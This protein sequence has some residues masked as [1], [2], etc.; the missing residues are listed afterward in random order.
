MKKWLSIRS[1]FSYGIVL[2]VIVLVIEG[3]MQQKLGI[4]PCSLCIF[5]RYLILL[6]GFFCLLATLHNPHIR[7][8]RRYAVIILLLAATGIVIVARQLWLQNFSV[9]NQTVET[10]VNLV[11]KNKSYAFS[12]ADILRDLSEQGCAALP[13]WPSFNING[14]FA[15][16]VSFVLYLLLGLI[17]LLRHR[18][19]APEKYIKI[20]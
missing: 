8:R 20:E 10:C 12:I 4:A 6:L 16:M 13:A 5:Y 9:S 19:I 3:Y 7:P 2:A 17:Q 11:Y 1:C 18:K 14:T 15:M